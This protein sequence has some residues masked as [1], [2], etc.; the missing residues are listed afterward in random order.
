MGYGLKPFVTWTGGKTQLA[1]LLKE[2]LPDRYD[3]YFE[4]FIGGEHYF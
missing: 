4:P 1:D 2:R 3:T